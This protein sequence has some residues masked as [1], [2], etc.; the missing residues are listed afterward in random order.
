MPETRAGEPPAAGRF[1]IMG[2]RPAAS[3]AKTRLA[4]HFQIEEVAEE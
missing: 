4:V 3:Q 2:D 1:S